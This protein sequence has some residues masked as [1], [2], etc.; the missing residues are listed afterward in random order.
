MCS[1]LGI[2]KD[3]LLTYRIRLFKP[4]VAALVSL[5]SAKLAMSICQFLRVLRNLPMAGKAS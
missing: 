3:I 5:F 1:K 4:S 2:P